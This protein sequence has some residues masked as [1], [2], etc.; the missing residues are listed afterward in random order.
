MTNKTDVFTKEEMEQIIQGFRKAPDKAVLADFV[1]FLFIS[2]LKLGE[3]SAIS[4][5]D[6]S[7]NLKQM[8]ICK[9]HVRGTWKETKPRTITLSKR[10]I[11][12]LQTRQRKKGS[13]VFQDQQGNAIDDSRFRDIWK[14]ALKDLGIEYRTPKAIQ[15][16]FAQ[17]CLENGVD[18]LQ[19]CWLTGY[20][21]T[22]L[23]EQFPDSVNCKPEAITSFD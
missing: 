9:M 5:N 22:F 19:I 13:L 15:L 11:D 3:V 8:T 1:E 23:V 20:T 10:A 18:L 7:P 17:I 2:G 14:K 6:I 4:W 16:T 12:I 21:P